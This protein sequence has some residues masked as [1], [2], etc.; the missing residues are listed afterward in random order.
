MCFYRECKIKEL[1]YNI[2]LKSIFFDI[3]SSFNYLS[4]G[5][6]VNKE[7][8]CVHGGIGSKF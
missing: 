7:Y 3:N 8:L 4:I 2:N 6:I 1:L 5:A